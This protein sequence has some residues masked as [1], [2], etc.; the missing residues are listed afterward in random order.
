L[1]EKPTAAFALSLIGG[2]FAVLGGIAVVASTASFT[3][4]FGNFLGLGTM[5]T[6]LAAYVLI[7]GLIILIGAI[8]MWN[9]PS[10][11]HM[12]G[13]VILILSIISVNLFGFIGGILAIVW[14]PSRGGAP[15][16]PS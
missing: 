12:W 8:M 13:I 11:T 14:K 16:P 15:P 10:S 1:G 3:L 5:F 7:V 2:I 9:N 6:M 4:I